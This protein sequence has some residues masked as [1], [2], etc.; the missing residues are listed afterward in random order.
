MSELTVI[1]VPRVDPALPPL[2]LELGEI[3]VV[4]GR[5]E[6]V[7]TVNTHKAPELLAL[8]NKGYLDVSRIINALEYE[9]LQA[10]DALQ[11]IKSIILLDRMKGI[12]EAKGLATK[13]SPLG[14]EDVRNAVYKQDPEYNRAHQL[15]D[16]LGCYVK[17][18]SDIRKYFQN[19]YDSVKKIIGTDG[20]GSQPRQN[21]HLNVPS[22]YDTRPTTNNQALSEPP[23]DDFFGTAR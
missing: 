3:Y 12:L 5:G 8:F 23:E 13:S 16:N 22:S 9:L 2:V 19:S 21:P 7:K 14:S 1:R 4:L 18:F 10:E 20:M 15:V 11:S 6:E 17:R